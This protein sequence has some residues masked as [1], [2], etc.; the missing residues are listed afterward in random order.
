MT[1]NRLVTRTEVGKAAKEVISQER[2]EKALIF[3]AETDEQCAQLKANVARAE[4]S[5]KLARSAGFFAS[6][7]ATVE[8]RKMDAERSESMNRAE[9]AYADAVVAF[10][11]LKAKRETQVII[12][13][14]WRS[15]FSARKAGVIT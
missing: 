10:E 15:L 8:A 6:D 5:I 11:K 12:I 2:L 7:E 1:E 9:A 13:D 14:V 3:L 4:Y